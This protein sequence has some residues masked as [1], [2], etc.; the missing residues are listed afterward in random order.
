MAR[1][2]MRFSGLSS[3]RRMSTGLRSDSGTGGVCNFSGPKRSKRAAACPSANEGDLAARSLEEAAHADLLQPP[4]DERP[5]HRRAE[6]HG[7]ERE[8]DQR[9]NG[10][11]G[12]RRALRAAADER[13]GA[14]DERRGDHPPKEEEPERLDVGVE[15]HQLFVAD[16]DVE[17][18]ALQIHQDLRQL[19]RRVLE[20]AL[21]LE[22][23]AQEAAAHRGGV[24]AVEK[25]LLGVRQRHFGDVQLGI[26]LADDP[27]G[28]RGFFGKHRVLFWNLY[29][30]LHCQV[31]ELLHQDA[32]VHLG[33][34]EAEIPLEDVV[35]VLA[36]LV[37][38]DALVG[39]AHL[40]EQPRHRVG[41]LE[42]DGQHQE[43]DRLLHAAREAA[44]QAEV[45]QADAVSLQHHD[46]A[47]MRVA[48]EEA[49]GKQLMEAG[50][51]NVA[52]ELFAIDARRVVEDLPELHAFQFLQR[53]HGAR[54]ELPVEPG[55]DDGGPP[56]VVFCKLLDVARFVIEI[57]LEEHGGAELADDAGGR[58]DAGLLDHSLEESRQVEEEIGVAADLL[59]DARTLH[60]DHHVLARG[61][62]RAVHLG[63]RRGRHRG[64]V[65]RGEE[66][67]GGFAQALLDQLQ[68]QLHRHG[69]GAILKM[70]ELGDEIRRQ[71]VGPR[72]ED[73]P[74]LDEGG[75]QLRQGLAE[76]ARGGGAHLFRRGP[77]FLA[78]AEDVPDLGAIP[79]L[80]ESVARDDHADLAQSLEVLY[81]LDHSGQL[82]SQRREQI[83]LHQQRV[84]VSDA[85][86]VERPQL[87]AE[88]QPRRDVFGDVVRALVRI[89]EIEGRA[90]SPFPAQD[91]V[92]VQTHL[93][94]VGA[95]VVARP[96]LVAGG[97]QLA[98]R[99][100][101]AA[102]LALHV[103]R[104]IIAD[105]GGEDLCVRLQREEGCE[106][107]R[108]A[109][110]AAHAPRLLGREQILAANLPGGAGAGEGRA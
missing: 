45:E 96:V 94:L 105:A 49:V 104:V 101:A 39:D 42:G 66:L 70:A 44:H 100:G 67:V 106:G 8:P 37:Q 98:Q 47:G 50:V 6:E 82:L 11:D 78:T 31:D 110:G 41:I 103:E 23:D 38:V 58:V 43:D 79:E 60:L 87:A 17:L 16:G 69:R 102:R 1:K 97:P 77:H 93:A 9:R 20:E 85:R 107:I 86:R 89:D 24:V 26:E 55:D 51:E 4:A 62:P 19:L 95:D 15:A 74:Q 18:A 25:E 75:P 5:T 59:L 33:E 46:V 3:T 73:L 40:V 27:F 48:V 61:E 76:A 29:L 2:V 92:D 83:H 57:Q 53:D 80:A 7:R 28:S 108:R 12:V 34:L 81:R 30:V 68:D 14:D 35:D 84:A 21:Q 65:D 54:G 99:D 88:I 56:G 36:E 71:D 63:D 10:P 91:E 32:G 13:E 109:Q 72:G 52:G 22:Q 90:G 64:G